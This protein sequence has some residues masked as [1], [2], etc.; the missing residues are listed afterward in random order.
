MNEEIKVHVVDYGKQRNLM[1]RYVDPMTGKHVSKSTGTRRRK[2]AD[3]FATKW[4]HDLREGRFKSP[5]KVSWAE[6]RTKY[7]DEVLTSLA[8]KTDKKVSAMF[9]AVER[10]VT[11]AK[12]VGLTAERISY[13][14]SKLREEGRAE[15]TIKGH[16]AHL[17]ASLNWANRIGLLVAVPQI[18]MPKRAKA[19]KVMKGRPCTGEEFDRMLSIVGE[20]IIGQTR[21]DDA[22]ATNAKR[23]QAAQLPTEIVESWR[24]YLRGLWWSGLRLE[25]SLMLTWDDDNMLRVDLS[26]KYPM[27]HIPAEL[28]KG[29]QDR[30]LPIAPE[31]GEFLLVTPEAERT[32]FVFTPLPVRPER[33]NRLGDQQVGRVVSRIGK[34]AAV[35]VDT[36]R[37][38]GKVKYA[39]AHDLRRSFG[40]RW[41]P[42]VM[43]QVL[44]ELMRHESIETTLKYYVG[45]NA[46][47]TAAALYAAVSGNTLSNTDD[48]QPTA[49]VTE[50]EKAPAKQGHF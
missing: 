32:G 35:A 24:H 21:D 49:N 47:T 50:N 29:N 12:L 6:F 5:S 33:S 10:I 30:L 34:A 40:E 18:D 2:E 48:F 19:S 23:I 22:D 1:A 27:L 13:L 15:S 42:R 17:K 37:K 4:E 20:G 46:E 38:T 11:P 44:M 16:M 9:N 3:R 14:Q 45:R 28:E 7:E 41:A 36:D 26:G 43:P 8:E 39:S 25:E 31:F